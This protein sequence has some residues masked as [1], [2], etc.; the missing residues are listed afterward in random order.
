MWIPLRM[1]AIFRALYRTSLALWEDEKYQRIQLTSLENALFIR[2]PR[3][4]FTFVCNLAETGSADLSLAEVG[5]LLAS[6][7]AACQRRD[8][9]DVKIGDLSWTTDASLQAKDPDSIAINYWG[10]MGGLSARVSRQR[11]LSACKEF[12]SIFGQVSK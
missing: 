5:E 10:P 9:V 12:S 4:N 7:E 6:I 11:L 8:I 1:K 2:F 3:P